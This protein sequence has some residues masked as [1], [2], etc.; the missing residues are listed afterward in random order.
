MLIGSFVSFIVFFFIYIYLWFS[1]F[2]L[3]NDTVFTVFDLI[4]AHC[5]FVFIEDLT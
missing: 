1:V 4:R 2:V 5:L 3:Q